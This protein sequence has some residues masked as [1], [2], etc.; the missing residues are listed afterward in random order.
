[1]IA[2][3]LMPPGQPDRLVLKIT[4]EDG[5]GILVQREDETREACWARAQRIHDGGNSAS[6]SGSGSA[7]V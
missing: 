4:R 2:T 1:M 5:T 6:C 7:D 3:V